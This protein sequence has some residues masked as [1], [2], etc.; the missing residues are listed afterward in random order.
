MVRSDKM[1]KNMKYEIQG[2][3]RFILGLIL[4]VLIASTGLQVYGLNTMNSYSNGNI[5]EFPFEPLII[6][7]LMFTLFGAFVTFLFYIVGSFK[8]ELYEDRGYLT[9]TLPLTGGQIIGSKLIVAFM[10]IVG[11]GIISL[12]YNLILGAIL[13]GNEFT[14]GL[15][16]VFDFIL[17]NNLLITLG[18][19]FT[20]LS[21]L[22]LILVY[23][24]ITLSKV[25]IKNKKLGGFWFIFFLILN[26]VVGFLHTQSIKIIPYFLDLTTFKIISENTVND[27]IEKTFVV[28]YSGLFVNLEAGA[29]IHIGSTLFAIVAIVGVFLGTAYLIENKLD[30]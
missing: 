3:Y 9:L 7:V 18:I 20:L 1:I 28:S 15:G 14:R 22:S 12:V 30:L 26:S 2:T 6:A 5:S 21:V 16:E 8:K 10:W 19:P 11:I 13:F 24:S 4:T 17:S 25:S 23:F 29:F 27:L